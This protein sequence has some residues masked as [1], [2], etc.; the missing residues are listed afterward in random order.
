MPPK[1]VLRHQANSSA[2]ALLVLLLTVSCGP[3]P[4][5]PTTSLPAYRAIW[6]QPADWTHADADSAA[7]RIRRFVTAITPTA[8]TTLLVQVDGEAKAATPDDFDPLSVALIAGHEKGLRV[9]AGLSLTVAPGESPAAAMSRWKDIARHVATHYGIDGLHLGGHRGLSGIGAAAEALLVKPYLVISGST[10]SDVVGLQ[11]VHS[12]LVSVATTPVS[13]RVDASQVVALD[14][15]RWRPEGASG[16]PVQVDSAAHESTTDAAGRVGILLPARPDT[17]RLVVDGDSLALETRF[18]K[19]PYRFVVSADGSVTRAAP[20]VELRAA[21]ATSTTRDVFEFLGHT[22]ATAQ[23][24][25]NG[26]DTKVYAT[27]VFFDSVALVEGPNRVR[28]E[29]RWP[30]VGGVAVYEDEFERRIAPPRPALPLWIDADSVEP[31]DTLALLPSDNLRLSFRGSAGQQATARIRP[32]NLEIPFFQRSDDDGSASYAADL[33]LSRLQPG[34]S[35]EV[36]IRLRQAD[37]GNRIRHRL[38]HPIEVRE[39]HDFPLLVTSARESYLSWSL[40]WVRLGGP[41]AAEFPEGVVLQA[42]GIFGRRYRVR[43]GP[44]VVGFISRRHVDVAP[45]GTVRPHFYLRSLSVSAT[46]STDVVLIPRPEP[47]P[48]VVR[49]DPDG[50]RI[51]VTLYGV[52]TSSTWLAHRTGL[53]VV[54]KVTWR[55]VDAETYEAAIHLTSDRIWGYDVKPDG[56]ALAITLRHP[57]TLSDDEMLPLK[58]L[59]IA[60]EAGHGGSSTGAIGLSGLLERDVNLATALVLGDMCRVAGAEVVQL[61]EGIDGV[62]YMARRDSVRTSGADVFVSVH[63]NAA[64]GGFLRAGGTSTFYH[65]PFW[66]SLASSIYSRMLELDFSE[67]GTV[68]SFNYRPTRMSSVPAVLVEQAF[69]THAEDEEFLASEAG[70]KAIAGKIL[71]GLLGWLAEQPVDSSGSR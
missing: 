43:F 30:H 12:V 53:R 47:V 36:E 24:S 39:P 11:P 66:A 20:W 67:F 51:L 41:Y 17:L 13:W 28:L 40:G 3:P 7:I 34:R 68:G 64:G 15:S 35:Y 6:L 1:N 52:E 21:P 59:K 27:G 14:L 54:D 22:D 45:A 50:R 60:I 38:E 57:P 2:P 56:G 32:G 19:P 18:W 9:H 55:Q 33:Q 62:P 23:A 16:L 8:S 31:S 10:F 46:D 44:Q 65:D 29:A 69:M 5:G 26:I 49:S 25:V 71:A 4:Q 42:N 70:R 37:G 63:A 58:G 48:Y 61:R